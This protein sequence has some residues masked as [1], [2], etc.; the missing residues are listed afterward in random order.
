M[1]LT[2]VWCLN[3]HVHGGVYR[4][5]C[6]YTRSRPARLAAVVKRMY[7][8]TPVVTECEYPGVVG[9]YKDPDGPKEAFQCMGTL[10]EE[11]KILITDFCL[12]MIKS[13][14][15][16]P[17]YALV[18]S[19]QQSN[20]SPRSPTIVAS[21][22]QLLD[23]TGANKKLYTISIS[24]AVTFNDRCI[25]PACVPSANVHSN[26]IDLA[27]C[28]IV[29]YGDNTDTVNSP[30]GTLLEVKVTVSS[31]S[32]L[33]G[34]LTYT[35]QDGK[36]SRTGPCLRDQGAPLI[37]THKITGEWITIGV[38]TTVG[39]TCSQ[40]TITSAAVVSLLRETAAH[41]LY[42]GLQYFKYALI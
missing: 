41:A 11:D 6:Y 30:S 37:C 31:G 38:V 22:A 17:V 1:V 29:G 13:N 21:T 10:L 18:D 3:H 42:N 14:L 16:Q 27:D 12:Q 19:Y 26:E 36:S 5:T 35:R 34:S 15:S 40:G 2:C 4:E 8:G 25:Q 23:P 20:V 32:I 9:L 24:P 33:G 39:F 7:S 28:R